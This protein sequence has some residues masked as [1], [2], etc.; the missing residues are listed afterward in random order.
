MET[1]FWGAFLPHLIYACFLGTSKREKIDESKLS[2]SA[3]G[4]R[5]MLNHAVGEKPQGK[6]VPFFKNESFGKKKAK[7]E[8]FGNAPNYC[9][10]LLEQI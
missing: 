8:R 6:R 1:A 4:V 5:L 9:Y 10:L 3:F 2:C 7:N